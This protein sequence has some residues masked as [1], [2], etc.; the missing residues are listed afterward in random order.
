MSNLS[1][2]EFE[3]SLDEKW[4]TG[5]QLAHIVLCIKATINVFSMDKSITEQNFGKTDRQNRTYEELQNDYQLKAIEGVKAPDRFIPETITI[6]QAQK[7]LEEF[8]IDKFAKP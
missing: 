4:S 5:Q 8:D 7:F 2:E 3:F 6:D 1:K